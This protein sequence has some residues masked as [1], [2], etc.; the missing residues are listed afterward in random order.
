MADGLNAIRHFSFERK[1]KTFMKHKIYGVRD[2]KE[3]NALIH[4]GNVTMRVVFQGG[5][6][7]KRGKIP[8]TYDTTDAVKQAIIEKSA[9]FKHG[10]IFV[11]QSIEVPDDKET[12]ERKR[13]NAKIEARKNAEKRDNPIAQVSDE[14]SEDAGENGS[15][16]QT[17]QVADKRDA[18]DWLKENFPDKGYT[19]NKLKS[20]E[21]FVAACEEC[22]VVFEFTANE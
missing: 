15:V 16:V 12:L 14:N 13:L 10:K 17:I 1:I 7:T 5:A 8:A 19:V 22:N 9:E 11:V 18:I 3:W 6:N 21:S 20:E 4:S 2:L